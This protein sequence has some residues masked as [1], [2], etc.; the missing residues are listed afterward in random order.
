MSTNV[1]LYA[2]HDVAYF[3][4]GQGN[5]GCAGAMSYYAAAG[6]PPGEWAG[7]GAAT[8]GLRGQ[9]DPDVI[10]RL[11]QHN[12]GPGAELL[13]SRRR[14]KTADEREP[15]AVAAYLAAHPYASATELA[16]VRVAERGKDP[17]QVPY[18]DL[19]VSA[20]KSVSVLHAS[21]RVAARQARER[22][23]QEQAAALDARADAIEAALM[24]SAREAVAWLERHAT[25]TRTGHHSARTGEW[26]D[27]DGLVASVFLHHLSRDGD[28]QLHVHV[29]VWNRVQRADGADA[30]WRTLDSRSLHNQ[31][32]AVAPAADRI[33]ETR[34]SALGYAMVPRA[35]G[36][37]AEI[38]GVSQDVID[39]FSSRAVAVTDE[40]DRLA[41]EYQVVHGK[42]PSRRTLWLL[43]QQAGQNTRRTKAQAR[44]T[45][46]GQTGTTEPT[47]AQR[48]AAWEAQ[49]V[50]REVQA[51]SAVHEQVARFAA[52][53]RGRAPAVV[54]DAAKRTAARIAV[55][56][57]QRHHAVWSMAQ[58]RFE[59]HRALPVLPPGADGETVVT[60]VARLAVAGRAGA[61][62]VQVTAPDIADVTGL[63]VRAS[64]GG[65]IYRPPNQERYCTLAHL[66][67]EEQ[68]LAA[69][70]RS[71]PQLVGHD[72]ARSAATRTG[73]NAGQRDAVVMMLTAAAATTVLVASAGAGKSHTMA[74]FAR[75]WTA[76]TGRRVIGLTTSTNAARVLAHEGLAESYNIAEFLGKV[77]SSDEL[78][79]PV[80]LHRDDVLVLDEASQLSTADLAMI[81]EAAWQAGARVIATGDTAQ[82]GAVE[83]GGVF[84]LLAGEVPTAE[85][86]EV[87]RF[88][89]EW[90]R[91]ASVRL[92]A[93]DLAAVAG[94]DHHRRIR[95]GDAEAAC[96]RAASMWLADHLRGKDVLLLAGSN[97]EAADLSRRVQAKLIQMGSVG[98]PQAPLSDGN[99]AGI[100]DLVRARLN[101]EIDAGGR[102]LT[103][104]DT[105]TVTAF[106]GPD[107]VVRRQRLDGTWTGTFRVPRAYLV[108]S[109]ELAYAGNIHVAQGRTVDTAHLLVTE[110][111]SRQALYVGMTR[112]RQ[113]N[114]AHVVT[115][116]TAPPGHQPYQQATPESVLAGIMQRDDGDLS[117]TEQIRQSQDQSGGTG[118]LLTLWTAAVKQALYPDIDRQIKGRLT[119]SEAWRYDREPSRQAL[120]QR[121]RAAQ[122]AGHDI[123]ALIGQIMA[124]PMDRARSISSVLHGR[125]QHI[126]LPDLRHDATWAQ[127]TPAAAPSA[128]RE[129]AAALD[130]RAR[131]LGERAAASP[132]PWLARRLG[133]LA[134]GVSPALRA[135]Y[136]RRAGTAAAYR[137]AAGITHPDQAVS[138]LPHRGNPELEAMRKVVLAALEIR[139]EADIIR[140]LDRGELEARV[141][142]GERARGA[143]PPDVSKQLRLTAQA[144]ADALQ[145][146]ADAQARRDHPSAT[147]ATALAAQL[148]A[149][150][151]RLETEDARY[152]QWSVGTHAIRDAAGKAAAELRRRGHAQAV[153]QP[154]QQPEDEPRLTAGW[155]QELERDAEAVNCA[156]VSEQQAA[157]DTGEL[158]PS[159]R[160][161]DT[162]PPSS[163]APEP[164]TSPENKPG[165]EDRAARLDELQARADQAAQR[166]AARQAERHASSGYA[167]RMELQA[168]TQAEAGHQ[169][170]ARDDIELELLP[171]QLE[172]VPARARDQVVHQGYG[173]GIAAA[174]IGQNPAR[175]VPLVNAKNR[176]SRSASAAR[177]RILY[178][179]N[180]SPVR[181][182][183]H[184]PKRR[185][186]SQ[187]SRTILCS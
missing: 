143:A 101:T 71:V 153:G 78:R 136:T 120:R 129:L 37:G 163:P 82:L 162:N 32:L 2:G 108:R 57:V 158:R 168:Q 133:V 103:N 68:I 124:A 91:Q 109:A 159:Q 52:E 40:L 98:P 4:S 74:V 21:Y 72:Q 33:L 110:T 69:A 90:E 96:D 107:A 112:G 7:K 29:A 70:K 114:T 176:P 127:R 34:L 157:S 8:L 28:P 104:R 59:V 186:E 89:A 169:A 172:R 174:C 134:S 49:T 15:A 182:G 20:V 161:P 171:R 86:H 121:L 135:E 81:E 173:L 123:S 138:L 116:N 19:T 149:E 41:Q 31:R 183:P 126:A 148:A 77:E 152:E 62:V 184:P 94:Y 61:G 76:F 80:P 30:K 75:L 179:A 102:Q 6:E 160:I 119:E 106:R 45:I 105:L 117:A 50:H 48:L 9:V 65:S 177:V 155:L 130:D 44:R 79:R 113:A 88:D 22:G 84:R 132:E 73:L 150:R 35:D 27:G 95:G 58:L 170:E 92:R 42:P 137:E 67:T 125:L 10:G 100:G 111:L 178:A 131:A 38:G 17:H 13:I 151:Q 16:E 145:Q 154:Q 187:L 167:A 181:S 164:R 139:D 83:A 12:I 180:L 122:L 115:G 85:L 36:N 175:Q 43:H 47:Q 14:S 56:E 166:I 118:H 25:Y 26:R 147:G 51:L 11:Y 144:E 185:C 60:E 97:A 66:D 142:Q 140:G 55:A 18:F 165:Q 141:L 39:L 1:T 146:S 24:D 53:R 3:T 63:G 87:R 128:A 64:D 54:D 156:D 5:G 93:G 99:H 46:A 23:D